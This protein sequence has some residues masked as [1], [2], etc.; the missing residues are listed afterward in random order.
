MAKV[1]F[2][3]SRPECN[4]TGERYPSQIRNTN[5]LY[6]SVDCKKLDES[7]FQQGE[8][9]SNYRHGR[10]LGITC[11][12]GQPKDYRSKTCGDCKD[13]SYTIDNL[14]ASQDPLDIFILGTRRQN[15]RVIKAILRLDLMPYEC[16]GCG[17]GPEWNGKPITL[18]LD[19]ENG[20]PLDNRL[21]NLRFLCPNCHSQTETW[22]YKK[23]K[24]RG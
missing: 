14:I 11:S 9:N 16:V 6:C 5:R 7:R 13:T 15:Q 8:R 18:Q 24:A 2:E 1:K 4:N 21:E 3:C 23:G 17:C 10:Y 12:C 20:N 22:G 19:H